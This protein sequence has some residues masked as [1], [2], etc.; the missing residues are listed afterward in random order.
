MKHKLITL[1]IAGL[2]A[3]SSHAQEPA[4]LNVVLIVAD[5]LG[6]GDV[7]CY[8]SEWIRTPNLDQLAADGMRATDAPQEQLYNLRTDPQQSTNVLLQF[9]EKAAELAKRFKQVKQR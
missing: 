5:D 6:V 9:P 7:G 4:P 2:A 3:A 8:G 1:L